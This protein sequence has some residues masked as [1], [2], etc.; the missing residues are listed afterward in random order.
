VEIVQVEDHLAPA[1][2]AAGHHAG[3]DGSKATGGKTVVQEIV[4]TTEPTRGRTYRKRNRPVLS[5]VTRP[6]AT[7][8]GTQEGPGPLG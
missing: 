8:R 4:R 3:V 2:T 5:A 1:E 7:G 6:G